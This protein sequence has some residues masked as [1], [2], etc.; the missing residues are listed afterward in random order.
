[1]NNNYSESRFDVL[2]RL[3]E[4]RNQRN[5]SVYKLA[6][7][8]GIPQSSIATWYQKGLYPPIDKLEI[9]CDVLDITLADFFNTDPVPTQ[10]PDTEGA[11]I[12][13]YRLLTSEEKAAVDTVIDTILKAHKAI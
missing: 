12:K 3:T 2:A 1:M 9:L 10:I 6:K 7:L 4:L 5:M 13:R 8:S 11:L